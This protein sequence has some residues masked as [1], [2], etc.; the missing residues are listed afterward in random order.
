MQGRI[1]ELE[2]HKSRECEWVEDDPDDGSWETDWI[3]WNFSDD[4]PPENGCKY[5]PNCGSKL[6]LKAT[7]INEELS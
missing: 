3:E 4:G 7:A 1:T 2:A 6:K 5:C